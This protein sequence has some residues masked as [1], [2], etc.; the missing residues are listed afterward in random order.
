MILSR[1]LALQVIR[2]LLDEITF[3]KLPG[4]LLLFDLAK[5]DD[6]GRFV[7]PFDLNDKLNISSHLSHVIPFNALLCHP[8]QLNRLRD[9][10]YHLH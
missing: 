2:L 3:N 4:H 7:Y 9:Y 8:G 6:A 1:A 10:P 5:S